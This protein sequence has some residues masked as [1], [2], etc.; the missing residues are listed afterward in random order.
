MR[1]ISECMHQFLLTINNVTAFLITE[2]GSDTMGSRKKDK[3]ST[4][5]V[6]NLFSATSQYRVDYT[7]VVEIASKIVQNTSIDSS[8][9]SVDSSV[10]RTG[11]KGAKRDERS[12]DTS[13]RASGVKTERSERNIGSSKTELKINDEDIEKETQ[14]KSKKR[15]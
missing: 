1:Y 9:K 12:G 2:I 11:K 3:A 4:T 7:P 14:V 15:A 8:R 13:L 10:E 6:T 5:A